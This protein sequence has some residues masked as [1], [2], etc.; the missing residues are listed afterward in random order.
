[1][2]S[3]LDGGDSR[4]SSLLSSESDTMGFFVLPPQ[5]MQLE[6]KGELALV[7]LYMV[8]GGLGNLRGLS[9]LGGEA[10]TGI[11]DVRGKAARSLRRAKNCEGL[12]AS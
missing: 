3:W 12:Y 10:A 4:T 11:E 6:L 9:R 7:V 8:D 5:S 2:L 1:V